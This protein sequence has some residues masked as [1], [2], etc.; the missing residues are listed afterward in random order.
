MNISDFIVDKDKEPVRTPVKTVLYN[1]FGK[2]ITDQKDISLARQDGTGYYCA[3][4]RYGLDKGFLYN[5]Q[6]EPRIIISDD[7][8]KYIEFRKVKSEKFHSYIKYLQTRNLTWLR[9]ANRIT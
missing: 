5:V 8:D 4:M 1:K 6:K 9:K 2:E 7:F 3:F